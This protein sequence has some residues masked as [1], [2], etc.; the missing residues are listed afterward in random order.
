MPRFLNRHLTALLLCL[1]FGLGVFSLQAQPKAGWEKTQHDFGNIQEQDGDVTVDFKF[2]NTGDK[3]L[4]ILRCQTSCGCT[5]PKYTRK[6]LKPGESGTIQVTYHAKGRPGVFQKSVYV[7]DNSEP[8]HKSMLLITGNVLSNR[9][10]EE[11]FSHSMG[12]GLR[13]KNRALNFF[14]VYP[15]RANRTRTMDVYNEG[16]EPIRLTFRN[17][18]KHIAIECEPEVLQPKTEGKVMVTFL[19][20]R[21]KD[22]GLHRDR[23]EVYVKGHETQMED[24]TIAVSADIWED[25]STLS[26]K[27]RDQAPQIEVEGTS[28]DFGE[29]DEP[30]SQEVLIT[31][32]GRSK[33][34]IRKIQNDLPKVFVT[35]VADQV[36]KPGETTTLTIRFEPSQTTLLTINHHITVIT[37]DPS[38]S[39]VIVNMT[40]SK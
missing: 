37:D 13:V 19:T 30:R 1:C 29:N 6:P 32:T 3:P 16:T 35:S 26:R 21:C 18:P 12:A 31:N 17:V 20:S 8:N 9:L 22:W 15:N 25:F 4:M 10:P 7:Y 34:H 39:R 36:V 2:T 28:L 5:T 24:N 40:A 23:F 38:N 11:S 27:E 33:L 14:D